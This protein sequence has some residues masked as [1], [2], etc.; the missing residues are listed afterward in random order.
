MFQGSFKSAS[1]KFLGNFKEVFRKFQGCFKKVSRVFQ[2]R[3]NG[4]SSNYKG[5]SRVFE[6]SLKCVSGKF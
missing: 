5:G 1:M 3:L 2:L 6:R 4:I